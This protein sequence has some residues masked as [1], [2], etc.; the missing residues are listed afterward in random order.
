MTQFTPI[1]IEFSLERLEA[2][3]TKLVEILAEES[4]DDAHR[5][6]NEIIHEV[7]EA[8]GIEIQ[9]NKDDC[10]FLDSFQLTVNKIN[11]G[12]RNVK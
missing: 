2:M 4:G 12:N 6:Y 11:R 5:G 10:A 8:G 7:L 9:Y 1:T 3:T